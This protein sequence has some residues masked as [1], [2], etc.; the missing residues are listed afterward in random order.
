MHTFLLD[1]KFAV[2]QL[3]KSRGF[4]VVAL[5]TLALGIGANTALFTVVNGVLLNPLPFSHPDQLVAIHESKPNFDRGS[6]SFPNFRDWRKDNHT[7]SSMAVSRPY[8]MG[9]TGL[10]DPEQVDNNFITSD[11]FTVLGVKPLL[12]RMFV[13][14]E[15]EIGAPPVVLLS[16]GLWRRKLGG[17]P[18]AVGSSLTLDGR[19]YTIV[20]VVP[21]SFHLEHDYD[22]YV[23]LGQW[24]N[25]ILNDRAAGLGLH[26]I[27]RMKPGVTV[28]QA[29]AD[30]DTVARSLAQ[31]YP[32]ANKGVGCR[33]V[34]LKTQI[35]GSIR[36]TL[37]VLLAA[38][39]FVLLIA[40]VNV[41]NLMLARSTGRSREFAIRTAMGAGQGRLVRQL[42][43]ESVLLALVGGGLGLLVAQL[44]TR[45]ALAA[46]PTTLPRAAEIGLDIRVLSFTIAVSCLVGILFGLVPTFRTTRPNLQETLKEGGRGASGIRH[47]AQDVFVV[48]EMALAL[49][50]LVGAGLLIRSLTHLWNVDPGFN[51]QNVLS[52]QISFPPS[53]ANLK[54]DAMRAVLRDLDLRVASL[55]GVQAV[56]QTWGAVPLDS[57][58]EN[59]FWP[60]GQPKPAS[61]NDMNWA[62]DYV[63]GP[64]YLKTMQVPLLSGRF[65]TAQDNEHS[66]VVV[67]VDDVFAKKFYP[68]R[69]PVGQRINLNDWGVPAEI[70]GVVGHVKQWG[71]DS[72]D[73]RPLRAQFYLNCL[74]MPDGMMA[75]GGLTST[76][77]LV[78]TDGTIPTSQVFGSIRRM[79]REMSSEQVIYRAQTMNEIVSES[80]AQR[81]FSVILLAIF[82]VLALVLASVGIYGVISYVVAR[83]TQE[84]GIR[85]A[86]GADRSDVARMVL[87]DGMRL[88]LVGVGLG[89][90]SAL[91]LTRLMANMLYG[92]SA[93]DPLTFAAIAALLLAVAFMACYIPA[94][95]ATRVD[96][97]IALRYD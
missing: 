23:P 44:G 3:L 65:V 86:L 71:L 53:M 88:A 90:V 51:P 12:G 42:L 49:V 28:E 25:P 76:R 77:L 6:I 48:L 18:N 83:R 96:P 57:D 38:V 21:A 60:A 92:V 78:R 56:S 43:T 8:A 66:P 95:R 64:D 79:S 63:I 26:G 59:V 94:R 72:D 50:L 91:L 34:P 1:V 5:L 17:S 89:V 19:Q 41:A 13:N 82:A 40:C 31:A 36:S 81:R 93:T 10:G 32:D 73:I 67:V 68:G 80:L 47:R 14:G 54:P 37:L 4:T 45:A 30:M 85:M 84:I 15:D 9:L 58:D 55:P 52:F 75:G 87:H 7:F 35:V 62:I 22:L 69:D 97:V 16:E 2:R 29:Q 70:V 39:G 74:Q 61:K 33:L 27:G 11:Y 24:S 46:L 20:G